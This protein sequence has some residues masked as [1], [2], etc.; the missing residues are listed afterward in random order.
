MV[1]RALLESTY[2]MKSCHSAL[3][4]SQAVRTQSRE[5]SSYLPG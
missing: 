5:V 1:D 4:V 3:R 2:S